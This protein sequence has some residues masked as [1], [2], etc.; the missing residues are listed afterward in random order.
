MSYSLE[1][2]MND[3]WMAED[4]MQ[5]GDPYPLVYYVRKFIKLNLSNAKRGLLKIS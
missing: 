5:E 2:R 4:Y 3:A 1:N